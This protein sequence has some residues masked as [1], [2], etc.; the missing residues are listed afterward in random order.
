MMDPANGAVGCYA[1]IEFGQ[2][3][4]V[5]AFTGEALYSAHTALSRHTD[6]STAVS[7]APLTRHREL[8]AAL[9]HAQAGHRLG[10]PEHVS[11]GTTRRS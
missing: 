6:L 11:I 4:L 5:L 2:Y 1:R 9:R 7:A 10:L 8:R 3:G